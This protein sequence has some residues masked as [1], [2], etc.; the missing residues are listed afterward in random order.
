ML[1]GS[2]R[3]K[4]GKTGVFSHMGRSEFTSSVLQGA[5]VPSSPLRHNKQD[6]LASPLPRQHLHTSHAPGMRP[7]CTN[8]DSSA[9]AP[10][11]KVERRKPKART[12][13]SLT[14]LHRLISPFARSVLSLPGISSC[15]SIGLR[16]NAFLRR[17][18]PSLRSHELPV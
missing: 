4:T 7:H 17:V 15:L 9:S 16:R 6:G 10:D 8:R 13:S 11:S 18:R 14:R 2:N 1:W 3:R 12:K 5:L